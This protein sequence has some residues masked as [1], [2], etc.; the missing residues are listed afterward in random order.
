[1]SCQPPQLLSRLRQALG[2][3]AGSSAGPA[4]GL[5]EFGWLRNKTALLI[6]DAVSREH[7][8]NLC[9]LLGGESEVVRPGHRFAPRP[10]PPRPAIQAS[11]ALAKP[12]RLAARGF[13]VVKDTARPRMCYIPALDF[14]AV[15]T[16]HFGLDQEDF[17]H[18]HQLPHYSAP[19]PF[20]HRLADLVQPLVA[21]LRAQGRRSA[22]DFVEL[23]SGAW[24]LAR[25]AEQDLA[26]GADPAAPLGADRVTWYR[27]RAGQAMD[28]VRAAF[29]EAKA[30]TWRTQHYPLSDARERVYFQDKILSKKT[31]AAAGGDAAPP[32][33]AHPRI[34]QLD[35]AVRSLVLPSPASAGSVVLKPAP[36]SEFRLNRWGELLK[37][38]EAHQKDRLHGDPLPGGYVW[39]DVMLYEMRRGVGRADAR[40]F[41]GTH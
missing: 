16:M 27:F 4:P 25:W 8:D 37:G 24:D 39:T 36:H 10:A 22:P 5:A 40:P 2:L 11:H 15:S 35:G 32:H 14:L 30:L 28:R 38:H 41:R 1:V 12:D 9:Q 17:F 26:T 7:V 19:G 31:E 23:S 21:Q 29:P 34:A 18:S 13:K 20:E 3:A 6:G 33:F